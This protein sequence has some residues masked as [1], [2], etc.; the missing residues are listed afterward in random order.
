MIVCKTILAGQKFGMLTTISKCGKNNYGHTKWLCLCSCGQISVVLDCSLK[1]G[2]TKSCGCFARNNAATHGHT[3]SNKESRIYRTWRSMIG[4]CTNPSNSKYPIYG[5]R[6]INVCKQWTKFSNFL[7]D[8]GEP[9]TNKHSIDRIDN[10]SDYCKEN[11]RWA[12]S[13]QQNR[14]KRN[15]LF[16]TYNGKTQL[17]IDWAKECG[18]KYTTLLWR[19]NNGWSIERALTVST[20]NRKAN[21]E[22]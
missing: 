1:S 5:G 19:L 6:G 12:T 17:V 16:V 8:M 4:R 20:C 9:P 3:C 14:N 22:N 15:N 7:V 11:C 13:K 18:I 2:N 21:N 10:N